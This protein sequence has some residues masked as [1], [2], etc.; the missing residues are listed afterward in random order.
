MHGQENNSGPFMVGTLEI[1]YTQS[2]LYFAIYGTYLPYVAHSFD[3]GGMNPC[4]GPHHQPFEWDQMVLFRSLIRTLAGTRQRV[5][6][7]EAIEK[8][9]LTNQSN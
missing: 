8:K 9:V 2:F 7:I 4:E 1:E 5:V 3:S 6:R